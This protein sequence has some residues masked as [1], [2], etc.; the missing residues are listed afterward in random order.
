MTQKF[1]FYEEVEV[2]PNCEHSEYVGKK[3]IVMGVS[4]EN[5]MI[6]SYAITLIDGESGICLNPNC[7]KPTGKQFKREDFY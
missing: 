4:E 6:Y 5:G 7:L 3:G 1:N 2:L